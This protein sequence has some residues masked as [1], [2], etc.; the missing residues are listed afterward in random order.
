MKFTEKL[1]IVEFIERLAGIEMLQ[2]CYKTFARNPYQKEFDATSSL[3]IHIPKCAGMSVQKTVYGLSAP[4]G[5]KS[6]INYQLFDSRKFDK[7]FKFTFVRN[8]WDRFLS[9]YYFLK[10]GGVSQADAEFSAH[11]IQPHKTFRSFVESLRNK[12]IQLR[13]L[14]WIH[15]RPQYLFLTNCKMSINMDFIGRVEKFEQ[16]LNEVMLRVKNCKTEVAKVNLTQH[17]ERKSIYTKAEK[18]IVQDLYSRDIEL[19][20]YDF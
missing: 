15:F 3:F 6:A 8:P 9:A 1:E 12:E 11:F 13:V 20:E 16:D 10:K 17:P 4:I 2:K 19:F 18:D 5:H 7:Y 14:D